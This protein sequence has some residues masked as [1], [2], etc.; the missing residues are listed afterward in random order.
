VINFARAHSPL[1]RLR[2]ATARGIS[3]G[4]A[5]AVSSLG[6]LLVLTPSAGAVVEHEVGGPGGP[7]VGAQPRNFWSIYDEPEEVPF[8]DWSPYAEPE[9]FE[10]PDGNPVLHETDTYAIYWDPKDEYHGDWQH[11]IDTFLH[12]VGASSGA[13][14]ASNGALNTVFAVDAQYTDKGNKPAYYRSTY[15]AA[16]TDTTKYPT[17][18]NC[19]APAP[20]EIGPSIACLTDKQL[21]EQLTTFISQHKLQK[22]MG[23]I[24]YLLTPPGVTLCLESGATPTHCSDYNRSTP[25]K[26]A[27]EYKSASFQNSFCSYHSDINPETG[28]ENTILYAAIPWSA[29]GL[30]D[31][32]L[33]P[34]P[35]YFCQDGGFNPT[36]KPIEQKE[37][38]KEKTAKEKAEFTEKTPE[39][40]HK[41]EK[42]EALEGPHQEEPNQGSCP[43]ADGWCDAGL[44]DVIISQIGAEQQNIVTDP[45][46]N[47]WHDGAGNEVT[48][49]CRNF[50]AP[51]G[52]GVA[53]NE[54]TGAGTL[55]NQTLG[56]DSYYLNDAF[57]LAAFKLSYPGVPCVGG[58]NLVPL[59]TAPNPVDVGQI[60]GFD[61]MESDITLDA[62]TAYSA[63]GAPEKNYATYTWNFGDGSRGDKT[64]EVSG[65]APG[66]PVC[67]SP[68]LSEEPP[69]S[70]KPPGLWI[71][72]AASAFHPY[73]YGGT[74][75]VTLT[76][77]D[78]GGNEA[79][80]TK[81][82]T[83]VGA[84]TVETQAASSTT[85]TSATLNATVNPEGGEVSECKV[86]YGTTSAYGS[87]AACVPSPPGSGTSPIAVSASVTGLTANTTYHFR[88]VAKNSVGK[89]E[90][91]DET[92]KTPPIPPP[93]VVTKPASEVTQTSAT[94]NATVNPNG[95]EV[96][97]CK[98]E[99]GSTTAYG[100]SAP[101]SSLP[102]S[103]SSPVAVSASVTGLSASTSYHFRVDAK[104]SVGSG[105]G[106][107]EALKTL[108]V[109]SSPGP[110]LLQPLAT[111]ALA[112]V[113][114]AAVLSRSLGNALSGGLVVR[115]FVNEQVAGNFEVLLSRSI[116]DRLGIRGPAATGL[117]AGSA[118]SIVIAK[119]ILVT[120]KGGHST[121]KIQFSKA[122]AKR[123]RRLNRVSLMLRLV[124]RNGSSQGRASTTVLSVVNLTR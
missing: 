48:D 119:A 93:S 44:A 46:L 47:A 32:S 65:Y 21:Q 4:L 6:A 43:S 123:L 87:S 82:I 41:Q 26:E 42:L 92:F 117:P 91:S 39:E 13:A 100:S 60:V 98:F 58:S 51:A 18:G 57:N 62:G 31:G 94:L 16:Y 63:L 40:R 53:A 55:E 64:P 86:E 7:T 34:I 110:S 8:A 116:A 96:S 83:V 118:P 105:E 20:S 95:V 25:E 120:T 56:G 61:G 66:A 88:I 104:N 38:A 106:S 22:G 80:V 14:T 71:G 84:P 15:R 90:G 107:D 49:E 102:G 52:G 85:E 113:A 24:Y 30:G 12:D 122:T 103:G 124:V 45:L 27:G 70:R 111:P 101:C 33:N 37:K 50:F 69:A 5:C 73:Q 77:R 72:C 81:A 35:A 10:N 75:E 112:P 36:S 54:E 29:G 1:A 109:P 114:S 99:Y 59:F 3:V 76:V 89:S 121:I 79:S 17:S 115:Y 9:T 28:D 78:V 23:A 97:E 2:S 67:E 74:Y 68:W 11:L 19:T 108:A